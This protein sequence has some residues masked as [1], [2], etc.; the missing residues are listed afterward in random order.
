[1]G[2]LLKNKK[3][4]RLIRACQPFIFSLQKMNGWQALTPKT[5]KIS[6]KLPMQ[7]WWGYISNEYRKQEGV[8]FKS[9]QS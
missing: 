9:L 4:N 6:V 5:K 8:R 3:A 2:Y 1:M 7:P